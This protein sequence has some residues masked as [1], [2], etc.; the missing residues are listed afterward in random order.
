[1]RRLRPTQQNLFEPPPPCG[2][3]PLPHRV[4]AI[5]LIKALLTE[6]MLETV[7]AIDAPTTW[8]PGRGHMG[9]TVLHPAWY[10]PARSNWESQ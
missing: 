1:M 8:P 2:D 3:M 9:G 6:A 4:K 7:V 10:P 5:E